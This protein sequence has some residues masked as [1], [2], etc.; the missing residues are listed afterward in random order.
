MITIRSIRELRDAINERRASAAAKGKRAIVGLVPT[1]GY[2]HKGHMSLMERAKSECDIV[3]LSI[4]VNPLQFGPNEDFDN[5]PRD[6][7]RDLAVAE[8][9]GVHIVFMPDV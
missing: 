9:A 3:V 2:L 6:E 1:M 7:E 8:Q 4:F 5:Y